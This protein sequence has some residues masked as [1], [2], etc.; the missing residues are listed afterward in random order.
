[1]CVYFYCAFCFHGT[2]TTAISSY[3]HTL[4]LP[5]A[6]PI[7]RRRRLRARVPSQG[8]F[9]AGVQVCIG[10]RFR[11]RRGCLRTCGCIGIGMGRWSR[12]VAMLR[13]AISPQRVV[14]A[15]GSRAQA[16]AQLWDDSGHYHAPARLVAAG[17]QFVG[18]AVISAAAWIANV[19]TGSAA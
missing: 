15:V 18:V 10:V 19:E 13:V 1:M 7:Y 6:L 8:S 11:V 17:V 3:G 5:Y 12:Y 2:A 4:S 14:H 16:V 9:V